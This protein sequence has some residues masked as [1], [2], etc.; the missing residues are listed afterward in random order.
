M[1]IVLISISIRAL[2]KDNVNKYGKI[3][4]AKEKKLKLITKHN[5]PPSKCSPPENKRIDSNRPREN[6]KKDTLFNLAKNNRSIMNFIP[7]FQ[8]TL[9]AYFI[10]R[11]SL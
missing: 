5:N 2:W 4:T 6:K 7:S 1:I 9:M 3:K 11:R 10:L 8:I